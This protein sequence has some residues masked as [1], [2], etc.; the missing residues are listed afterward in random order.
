MEAKDKILQKIK[1]I[2]SDYAEFLSDYFEYV[3]KPYKSF[4]GNFVNA[5]NI[6]FCINFGIV[7]IW[8]YFT[9]GDIYGE[10]Q[11]EDSDGLSDKQEF[12]IPQLP[13]ILKSVQKVYLFNDF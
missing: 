8:L 2:N 13:S 12:L 1:E 4:T 5:N 3:K 9:I 7:S 10:Y 6:E 11:F